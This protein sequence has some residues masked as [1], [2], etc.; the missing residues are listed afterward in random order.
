MPPTTT[1]YNA[2]TGI[3]LAEKSALVSFLYQHNKNADKQDIYEAVEYA[4]KLKPS[5][6]GYVLI[7]K[8][9]QQIVGAIVAN[10][11][12]MQGYNPNNLFVFISFDEAYIEDE[13]I[14]PYLMQKAIDYADGDI[15]LHVEPDHPAIK[16][17]Q[18][19]GFQ[20]E[21]VELRLQ[22]PK[23]PTAAVA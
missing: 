14:I 9:N 17:Y 2:F 4:V 15:A 22:K 20:S 6:G 21:Y 18:K 3:S 8:Q 13:T 16:L 7:A 23:K 11:T 5:F 19:L 10:R 1:L 12:G